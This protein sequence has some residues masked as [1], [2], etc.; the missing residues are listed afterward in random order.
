METEIFPILILNAFPAAGKSEV[1]AYLSSIGEGFRARHFHVGP[2]RVLDDF[3]MLWTWF[4]EDDLLERVF[5]RPRLHTTAE[6]YFVHQDLWHLLIRRLSLDYQK[7]QR[8]HPDPFTA[9]IEFSRGEAQGGY[10][11][12]YG[13]LSAEILEK[14]AALYVRV[15]FKEA[16]RKNRERHNPERPDSILEHSLSDDKMRRLYYGDD[17]EVFSGGEA[18]YLDVRGFSVPQVVFDNQ[19]DLTTD[20]GEGLGRRLAERLGVLWELWKT[21]PAGA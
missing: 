16:A 12:A 13:H 10:R 9:I 17:W 18:S 21:R 3:P 4:E 7:L 2:I 20:G 15:S 14:A 6:G 5:D 11:A 19:D 1:I 8:D